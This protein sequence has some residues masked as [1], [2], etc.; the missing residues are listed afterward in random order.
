MT[1]KQKA[2]SLL[3]LARKAGKLFSGEETSERYIR[4]NKA[5]LIIVSEDASDN[6]KK[7]F[8]NMSAYRKIDLFFFA[9]K[10]EL[11]KH[12]G[13]EIRSV[14]VVLDEGFADSIR[15]ILNKENQNRGCE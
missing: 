14:V 3:G 4:A 12:I 5:K 7:K 9:S 10:E 15:N 8:T 13:K 6:T 1:D 11:G 2:F